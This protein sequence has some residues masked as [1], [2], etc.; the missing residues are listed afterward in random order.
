MGKTK[1]RD[2]QIKNLINKDTDQT[3]LANTPT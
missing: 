1:R 3:D 2:R